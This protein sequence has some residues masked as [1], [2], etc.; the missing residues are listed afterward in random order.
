MGTSTP[1]GGPAGSTPL[2]PSWLDPAGSTAPA[3]AGAPAAPAAGGGDPT[4]A[5]T[6]PPIPGPGDPGR[7]IGART[8]LTRFAGSGGSGRAHLGRAVS[9]YVSTAAGG[10]RQAASRMGA[11]RT[12][13]ARLLAFLS[14]AQTRGT[15]EALRALDLE[16]LAGLPIADV[17][18]GLA[19][20][21][22]PDPGTIDEAIACDAFVETIVDLAAHGI[23]DLDALTPDQVQTVFELYATHAI[24]ARLCNDIGARIIS[25]PANAHAALM[26]QQQ[27]R[28]FIRHGVSDALA[29]AREANP[30][31]R[32]DQIQTF[33]DGVYESAFSVLKAMGDAEED[34]YR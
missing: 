26:V 16:H 20:Y 27:L 14:D 13:G 29:T 30:V 32:A 33:V 28:E 17:F 22:C 3:P 34:R 7:F 23:T 9:R 8:S 2:V 4:Q 31:L 21:I 5:P 10:A 24:E 12:S 15:R 1:Y 6:L 25:V 19:D 18:L 11:S